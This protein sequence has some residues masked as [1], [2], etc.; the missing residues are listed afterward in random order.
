[1]TPRQ[2]TALA[3]LV[4]ALIAAAAAWGLLPE[5][6]AEPAPPDA[7]PGPSAPR[8]TDGDSDGGVA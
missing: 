2:R 7:L 4:A 3:A 8:D 6:P 1:M 5:T